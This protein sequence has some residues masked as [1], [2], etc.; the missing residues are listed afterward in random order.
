VPVCLRYCPGSFSLT[1]W[2][3]NAPSEA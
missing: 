1:E 3:T 2:L